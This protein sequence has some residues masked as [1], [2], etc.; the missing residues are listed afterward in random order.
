MYRIATSTVAASFIVG[1][2]LLFTVYNSTMPTANANEVF[3][4]AI[5]AVE[6]VQSIYLKAR[7]RTLPQDNFMY[8]NL[9]LDFV[10]INMWYKQ[11]TDG[12]VRMRID[13]PYRQIVLD[14][15]SATMIIRNS[16]VAQGN[17]HG[18]YSCYDCGWLTR[19]MKIDELLKGE[20]ALSQNDS[21][22][23]VSVRH[24]QIDG[25][26]KMVVERYSP[27]NV[28]EGDYLRN[29]FIQD[30]DRT[31][32]YYFNP[33]T[34]LLEGFQLHV[35]VA[36]QD[37]LAFEIMEI[38]YNLELDDE[39]FT[40]EISDDAVFSKDPEILPD[41]EKYVNMT[42]KEA[43][44][45]FFTACA[46]NDWDEYLKFKRVSRVN[47]RAKSFLGSLEIIS[48]GEP[49]QSEGYGGWFVPYEIA[50]KSGDTRSHNL[51]LRNDNDANRWV[52][53]GGL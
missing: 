16:Y 22:Y 14:N 36:D 20:L 32:T 15:M 30:A 24:E 11:C 48:L 33:E 45:A 1:A 35:H 50:L 41:N 4:T 52:V 9:E 8:L 23:S 13:K 43:A 39:L 18:S 53:D 3:T 38:V 25:K 31:L 12:Q 21:R 47:E 5:D 26:K 42:P 29:S 19:L 28:S 2:I 40:L 10:P 6:D 17:H 49:F 34:K 46:E 27:A 7:M 37:V 44:Q 51:A